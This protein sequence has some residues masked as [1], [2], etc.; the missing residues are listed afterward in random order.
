MHGMVIQGSA[1]R[2]LNYKNN[3]QD[4]GSITGCKAD[5][6]FVIE[7]QSAYLKEKNVAELAIQQQQDQMK[8]N[9]HAKSINDE[10]YQNTQQ[11]KQIGSAGVRSASENKYSPFRSQR[12]D[13]GSL[14][15]HSSTNLNYN[16]IGTGINH[17]S[18]TMNQNILGSITGLKGAGI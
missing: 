9:A 12:T 2:R 16:N 13:V 15:P 4:S 11:Q 14:L 3:G 5:E 17:S 10:P 6:K 1:S 8:E 18:S 7:G